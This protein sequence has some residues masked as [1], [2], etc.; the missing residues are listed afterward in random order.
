MRRDDRF[1]FS[2]Q[3]SADTEEKARVGAF[4]EQL[5]NKKSDFIVMAVMEYLEQHPEITIPGAKIK[6]TYQPIQ[7]KEQ[8]VEMVKNMASAAVKEFLEGKTLALANEQIEVVQE[9]PSEQ[10]VDAMLAG[11][12]LFDQ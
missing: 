5:G 9:G 10:D 12:K 7:T 2:L 6:I 1:R 11:L 8:L 3:W 4:L